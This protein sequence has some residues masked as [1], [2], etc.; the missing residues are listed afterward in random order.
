MWELVLIPV[1]SFGAGLP[2]SPG[3]FRFLGGNTD[4]A[5]RKLSLEIMGQSVEA[6]VLKWGPPSAGLLQ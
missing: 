5:K 2:G 4:R 6:N 1:G 3:P